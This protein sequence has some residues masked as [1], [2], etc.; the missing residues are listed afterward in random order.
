M[1]V[2]IPPLQKVLTDIYNGPNWKLSFIIVTKRIKTRFFNK[3]RNPRPGTVVD[4][5]VTLPERYDFYLV[6]QSVRQG[7]VSPTSYNIISD[8]VGWTPNHFQR[9]TYKLTH[10]YYNCSVSFFFFLHFFHSIY[11]FCKWHARTHARTH[12]LIS[13]FGWSSGS[14]SICSQIGIFG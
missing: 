10:L 13:D 8:N 4:D 6:S 9:F 2:C 5:V 12:F 7:T 1:F 11:L 14:L 3:E